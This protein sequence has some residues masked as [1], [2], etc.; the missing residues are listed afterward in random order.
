M[1]HISESLDYDRCMPDEWPSITMNGSVNG[2][3]DEM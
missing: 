1:E 3:Y 2:I